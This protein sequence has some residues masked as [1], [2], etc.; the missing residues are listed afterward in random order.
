MLRLVLHVMKGEALVKLSKW[1]YASVISLVNCIIM[2][3]NVST[4][5]IVCFDLIWQYD[6]SEDTICGVNPLSPITYHCYR[7]Q[8]QLL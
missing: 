8:V 5:V 7:R 3:A 4:M 2:K 1:V 6:F